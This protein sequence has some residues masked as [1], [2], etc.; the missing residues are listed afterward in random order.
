MADAK[1]S[2]SN[3]VIDLNVLEEISIS[4]EFAHSLAGLITES[5]NFKKLS[6]HQQQS[7][8]ALTTFTFEVQNALSDLIH[9]TRQ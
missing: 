5:A 1:T 7:L 3:C 4:A 6:A 9:T 8:M 2:T